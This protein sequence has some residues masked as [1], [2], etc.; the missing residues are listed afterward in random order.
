MDTNYL[1]SEITEITKI[2]FLSSL[3]SLWLNF[4]GHATGCMLASSLFQHIPA[5]SNVFSRRSGWSVQRIPAYSSVFQRIPA[6]S[7]VKIFPP[8]F[9]YRR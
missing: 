1:T 5:Y 4:L 9:F 8:E 6:Y 2:R 7:R 3:R